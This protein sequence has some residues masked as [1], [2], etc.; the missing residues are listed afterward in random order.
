[1]LRLGGIVG[2]ARYAVE[3]RGERY[4]LA[5]ARAKA[6]RVVMAMPNVSGQEQ[7]EIAAQERA[8]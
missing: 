4:T 3:D 1:M 8:T 7:H 2:V 5:D 6:E